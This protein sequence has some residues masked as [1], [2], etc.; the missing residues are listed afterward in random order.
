MGVDKAWMDVDG[1]PLVMRAVASLV[2]ATGRAV[3][4]V[5]G[6]QSS[7]EHYNLD[8]IPDLH[9]G[10]GPL[11]G[12]ISALKTLERG[13]VGLLVTACDQPNL[14]A[15]KLRELAARSNAAEARI[16]HFSG[17]P[18]PAALHRDAVPALDG[19]F[20]EGTRSLRQAFHGM[21]CELAGDTAVT[22]DLDTPDDV[23]RWTSLDSRSAPHGHRWTA[24]YPEGFRKDPE[25]FRK[26]PEG[27]RKDPEGFR[28]DPEGFRKDPEEF[29][30]DPAGRD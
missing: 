15:E 24:S 1:T 19:R 18:L 27:F 16:V 28:K 30:K 10:N 7:A 14:R 3:L 23:V 12:V 8:W 17:E 4:A 20:S 21:N 9:P 13:D 26:D 25:E 22:V 11:G 2:Q 29:R 5:G 6:N